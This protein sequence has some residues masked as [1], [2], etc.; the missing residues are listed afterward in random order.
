MQVTWLAS[1]GLAAPLAARQ[2]T[3]DVE[4]KT[5]Y[6]LLSRS[7]QRWHYVF[8]RVLGAIFASVTCFTVLFLVLLGMLLL[9]Q[10]SGLND[11]ALWQA[12]CFQV[13]ALT[14]LCALTVFFS[15]FS[16]SSAAVTYAFIVLLVTRYGGPLIIDRIED[17]TFGKLL[18]ELLWFGYL[19]LP[20]FEFFNLSQRVV[21][22]WG[23]LPFTL[24]C[25]VAIYGIVYA[26]LLTGLAT[27]I[28]KRRWL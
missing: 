22:G 24:F 9:R 20:H 28:F 23:P 14:L 19:A 11:P 27:V 8:G 13:I 18:Q 25:L 7:I 6:V 5:A 10:A 15:T 17:M 12:Y 2:I 21:H 4:Q 1:F 26:L 3:S 16:T